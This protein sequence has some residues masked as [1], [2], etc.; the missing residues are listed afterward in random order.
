MCD[1]TD[2][3]LDCRDRL[4]G[5]KT[6]REGW[7]KNAKCPALFCLIGPTGQEVSSFSE[8]VWHM[9]H[10]CWFFR[11]ITVNRFIVS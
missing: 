10:G 7:R 5:R 11:A 2:R 9:T 1:E 6:E 3:K 4:R 8:E